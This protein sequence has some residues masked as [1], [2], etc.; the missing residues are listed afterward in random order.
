MMGSSAY[1]SVTAFKMNL[2]QFTDKTGVSGVG[3]S[4]TSTVTSPVFDVTDTLYS[5]R[6]CFLQPSRKHSQEQSPTEPGAGR[7]SVMSGVVRVGDTRHLRD[8]WNSV[9]FHK[10]SLRHS[11]SSGGQLTRSQ[12]QR[13]NGTRGSLPQPRRFCSAFVSV[14]RTA[15]CTGR[16]RLAGRD[17]QARAAP[18]APA[19]PQGRLPP[20]AEE[21]RPPRAGALAP[22]RRPPPQ[23]A[24]ALPAPRRA[25]PGRAEGAGGPP[26]PGGGGR[27]PR[28]RL[29]PPRPRAAAG[30]GT[31]RAGGG[32][33]PLPASALTFSD[34]RSGGGGGTSPGPPAAP[35]DPTATQRR[36]RRFPALSS[37]LSAAA[38][39]PAGVRPAAGVVH[40]GGGRCVGGGGRLQLRPR[41]EG[42]AGGGRY[43]WRGVAGPGQ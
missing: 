4:G 16:R 25:Q 5:C 39:A 2:L 21:E 43:Y 8:F 28:S 37:V 18:L 6:H 17:T 24:R 23:P 26:P 38:H 11:A 14:D 1:Y 10:T 7:G 35:R 20:S 3:T 22:P 33:R 30:E 27:A 12:L 32:A 41:C 31:N 36:G 13:A 34:A 19:S 9:H 40:R 42:P 15:S 29:P